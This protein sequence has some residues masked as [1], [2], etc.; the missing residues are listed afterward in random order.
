MSSVIA[1]CPDSVPPPPNISDRSTTVLVLLFTGYCVAAQFIL[2][3]K[4][5]FLFMC[6]YAETCTYEIHSNCCTLNVGC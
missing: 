5:S 3:F 1:D 2:H 4:I 6:N